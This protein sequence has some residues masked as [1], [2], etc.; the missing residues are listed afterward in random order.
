VNHGGSLSMD[1]TVR[2]GAAAVFYYTRRSWRH[3][4]RPQRLRWE[5]N[6][7][8]PRRSQAF[9]KQGTYRQ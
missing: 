6:L 8:F 9:G 7:P 4:P 3:L 5:S 2:P 1:A